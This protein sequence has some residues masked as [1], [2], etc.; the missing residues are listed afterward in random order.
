MIVYRRR[1]DFDSWRSSSPTSACI[2]DIFRVLL[3]LLAHGVNIDT[4]WFPIIRRTMTNNQVNSCCCQTI[5]HTHTYVRR[6]SNELTP[7]LISNRKCKWNAIRPRYWLINCFS[8]IHI[9]LCCF[10][11]SCVHLTLTKEKK[12]EEGKKADMSCAAVCWTGRQ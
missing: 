12:E 5:P 2:W 8:Y 10:Y 3:L 11:R 6:Y 9:S 4:R 1:R 7:G